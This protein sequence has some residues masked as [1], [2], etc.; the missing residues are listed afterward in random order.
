MCIKQQNFLSLRQ[1]SLCS[2]SRK[3]FCLFDVC[4][5]FGNALKMVTLYKNAAQSQQKGSTHMKRI[6]LIVL[7]LLLLCSCIGCGSNPNE[8]KEETTSPLVPPAPATLITP[9]N[10]ETVTLANE[11]L[12]KWWETFNGKKKSSPL[13]RQ[14][15]DLYFPSPVCFTWKAGENAEYYRFYLSTDPQFQTFESYLLNTP[16]LTLDHLHT[17]T[18]YYWKVYTTYGQNQTSESAVSC[19]STLQ[20]PRCLQI[21][22]VSNTRDIGGLHTENGL[23]IKQGMLYR[24]ANLDS[25]TENGI[26]YMRNTLGIRTDMDLRSQ[27]EANNSTVSPLGDGINYAVLDGRYYLGEKGIDAE[28][29]KEIVA[30]EIRMLADPDN[31]PIYFHCHI[32][33]DRTGTLAMLVE[34]LLGVREIDIRMDYELSVFSEAGSTDQTSVSQLR[35]T[36][37]VTMKY[38]DAFEG[39]T[40]SEKVESYLYSIGITEAEIQ[41]IR[42]ILLEEVP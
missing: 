1:K 39:E 27:N 5:I 26:A 41:T 10:D 36:I 16:S 20:S 17:E 9:A 18:T 29:S 38:F 2:K 37:N 32:G 24:G 15:G 8:G 35:E 42:S 13:Y 4:E 22:G 3:R 6:T 34:A 30:N 23:R 11:E 7:T 12:Y 28:G 19:F 14:S 40:L 25:I 33:R 31:Y 21:D